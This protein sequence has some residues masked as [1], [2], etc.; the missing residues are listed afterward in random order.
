V[1]NQARA[2]AGTV[3]VEALFIRTLIGAARRPW[4]QH[5]PA[6]CDDNLDEAFCSAPSIMTR[7]SGTSP[8]SYKELAEDGE[9]PDD[10]VAPARLDDGARHPPPAHLGDLR[11]AAD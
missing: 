8:S 2:S 4:P 7:R 11:S 1:P 9:P 3:E 10:P 6:G 5:Q